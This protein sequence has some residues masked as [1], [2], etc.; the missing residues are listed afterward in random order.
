M[1]AYPCTVRRVGEPRVGPGKRRVRG[2]LG[3]WLRRACRGAVAGIIALVIA[4]PAMA[5]GSGDRISGRVTGEDARPLVGARVSIPS[6]DLG[7]LTDADGRFVLAGV[8]AGVHTVVIEYL[9][10]ETKTVAGVAV[11]GELVS[12]HVML[13]PRAITVEGITVTA[14]REA[15]SD[16]ALLTDRMQA[17]AVV[18]AIGAAQIARSPDGNA[19][20][21]L[22]RLPGVS[23]VDGKYVYVRGLGDRYG[24]TTLNGAPLPSPEPDRK[25]VPLDLVP[26]SLLESVVSAKTYSP[27]QPGD[28]AG[29]LVQIRTKDFAGSR[30][31][32]VSASLGFDTE[33][34]FADGLGY[35]GGGLDYFGIEDGT[36]ALPAALPRDVPLQNL[37]RAELERIGEAFA[38]T[39]GPRPR[40]LPLNHGFGLTYGDVFEIGERRLG[41]IGTIS[42][43][44]AF[45][46]R[47]GQIERALS[48]SG[49][50]EPVIDF[51]GTA[52]THSVALGGLLHLGLELGEDDRISLNAVLNRL[53]DDEARTFEG[54]NLDSNANQRN[55]RIRYLSQSLASAQL[56]GEHR[57]GRLGGVGLRWR[58]AYSLAERYEPNTREMLYRE[59]ADGRFLWENFIQSASVFHQDMD[60]AAAA[61]G[62]DVEFPLRGGA[63]RVALSVGSRSRPSC[64]RLPLRPGRERRGIGA[65]TPARSDAHARD[66]RPQWLRDPRRHLPHGQLRRRSP[67][68]GGLRHGGRRSPAGASRPGW[69][70]SREGRA[71][72]LAEGPLRSRARSARRRPADHDGPAPRAQ[73]AARPLGAHESARRRVA[74]AR[75]PAAARAGAV[76]V[77]RLRRRLPG[78]RQ[79]AAR[80]LAHHEPRPAL[81]VDPARRCRRFREYVP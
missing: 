14:A 29:G 57:V 20:A 73:R 65:R 8:P 3:A 62:L 76:L 39:W 53:T 26:S 2:E 28:H 75:P 34:T 71:E 43:S 46:N 17:A 68:P 36:R 4:G 61:G 16:V 10:Y 25:V 69:G 23:V 79:H 77:R 54:L 81:G 51:L 42:H 1:G 7:A 63:R 78:P 80:A 21:A 6:L 48:A 45:S 58:A 37:S 35:A 22:K 64:A 50:A 18:D 30:T 38:G 33:A 32:G 49:G 47:D 52:S 66:D 13:E 27:D 72:R 40:R 12:L 19:A 70:K 5:Q 24:A 11:E 9:G 74:D 44:N 41:L 59:V 67:R 60:E 56:S 55:L 15:G 31:F